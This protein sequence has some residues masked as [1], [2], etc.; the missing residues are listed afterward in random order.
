[1]A[2]YFYAIM[3]YWPPSKGQTPFFKGANLIGDFPTRE[4]AMLSVF[5]DIRDSAGPGHT[6]HK[7][8]EKFAKSL[9][10]FIM[11]GPEIQEAEKMYGKRPMEGFTGDLFKLLKK[12][13]GKDLDHEDIAGLLDI[14][15]W[16]PKNFQTFIKILEDEEII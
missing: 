9:M 1:M 7:A 15:R 2:N 5:N 3:D 4:K 12:H 14:E 16:K 8:P 11:S 6:V 10:S 13:V